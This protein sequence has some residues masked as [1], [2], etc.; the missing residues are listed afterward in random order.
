MLSHSIYCVCRP[1]VTQVHHTGYRDTVWWTWRSTCLSE[2]RTRRLQL[3]TAPRCRSAVRR[4]IRHGA[5]PISDERFVWNS[6]LWSWFVSVDHDRSGAISAH[7]L[8]EY[9]KSYLLRPRECLTHPFI[10]EGI[11]QRRLDP[12]VPLT[13][14]MRDSSG[15]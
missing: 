7:E 5:S 6:R 10:R 15:L 9:H 11:G 3:P 13:C 1:S 12:Y 14:P 8:R 4:I 2:S